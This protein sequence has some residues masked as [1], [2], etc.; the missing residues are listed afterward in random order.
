M[1]TFRLA[2]LIISVISITAILVT[3]ALSATSSSVVL[4]PASLTT[5]SGVTSG[6]LSSLELLQQSN[7]DDAPASYIT[8]STPSVL[9]SGYFSYQLPADILPNKVSSFLFQVNFKGSDTS[10]QSWS[11]SVFNWSSQLWIPISDT[12]GTEPNIWND[13]TFRVRNFASYISSTR[14]IR[15][16]LQSN[17]ASADAK[18]DYQAIHLT[19][20]PVAPTATRAVATLISTKGAYVFPIT[21]TPL[22]TNTPT[23]TPS[24][25]RTPIPPQK[26]GLLFANPDNPR[27]FTDGTLVNGKYKVIYLTGS[28]T[29][30]DFMDCDDNAMLPDK[31]NYT[32]FLDFLAANNHNFFRLWRAENA[33]GG[34]VGDNFWFDPMPYQRSN[35]CCAFDTKN[36]F[37]LNQFDQSYFDR[38]RQRV[39][40]AGQRGFYVSIMLFDG[41]SVESKRGGHEPWKGHPFKLS[42]NINN[43][44]GDLNN[45]GQG[46]ETHTLASPQITALQDAYVRKVIDTVNDLDNVLFEISNESPA[47]SELWQYHIINYIR[48]YEATK[49]QQHAVG[50]T[51]EWPNDAKQNQDLYNSPADWI[52]LGGNVNIDTYSPPVANGAKVILAD[53]DH[54]CGICGNRQ[55][56]WRSFT[57]GENPIFMDSY[58]PNYTGRGVLPGYDPNN[59]TD[60]SLRKNLGYTKSFADRINLVAMAPRPD[61]CSTTYCLAN[62]VANGAEYL[63]YL[64]SGGTATVNLSAA[65][66]SLSVEWFNPATGVTTAA[67][68]VNGGATRSFT[69]PFSGDAV[70]YIHDTSP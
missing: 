27:Y 24:P 59:A 2:T 44:N 61:L 12:I 56:V 57:R 69:A 22:P 38:M 29:W 14:E 18:I 33:R 10:I 54:L 15:I 63:V 62:P 52:S 50:M 3:P 68:S 5:L 47:D 20:L 40:L 25:T 49:P 7:A 64:Q 1:R 36:K 45:D 66:G 8:F 13:L 51:W 65:S 43:I 39:I 31:F 16:R 34:E 70:L 42:N 28:H 19:Y 35:V 53:T 60:V 6:S 9:Y 23:I 67:A 32:A 11:W 17:N 21:F 4:T 26:V 48:S 58:D 55:W 46:G 37:D 30:C 41:W